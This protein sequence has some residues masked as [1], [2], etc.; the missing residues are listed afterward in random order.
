MSTENSETIFDTFELSTHTNVHT[1]TRIHRVQMRARHH[2]RR[3][4][5]KR[6]IGTHGLCRDGA[7]LH[8]MCAE[9]HNRTG[10]RSQRQ[11]GAQFVRTTEHSHIR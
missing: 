7:A 10:R 2:H 5:A 6:G 3:R 1:F 8:T 4:T 11:R 9:R